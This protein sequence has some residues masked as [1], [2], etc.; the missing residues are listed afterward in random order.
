[1]PKRDQN[2][3]VHMHEYD[4]NWQCRC[5]FRLITESDPKTSVVNIKAFVTPDGQTVA[6]RGSE[7]N[8]TDATAKP[9]RKKKDEE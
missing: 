9:A 6:L 3:K 1:M 4:D 8:Q 7:E 2:G 5:G